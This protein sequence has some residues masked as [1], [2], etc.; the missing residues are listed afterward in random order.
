MSTARGISLSYSL[1]K[2]VGAPV[3]VLWTRDDDMHFE[4]YHPLSVTRVTARMDDIS[5]LRMSRSEARN[6]GIP[7]GAWRA[8]T[9]IPDAFARE[10]FIDEFAAATRQDTISLHHQLLNQ[11]ERNALDLVVDL[12]GWG[13]PL[14]LG[15]GRG[16]AVFST[17]GVSPCA[18]VAEVAVDENGQIRI[19]KVYC[20]ID[21]GVV[22]NPDM[23]RAQ[24]EGGILFGLTSTL[25]AQI[26][27][28][29]GRVE[30]S[31]FHDYPL[32]RMDET[33]E[34]VVQIVKSSADPTGTGEMANPPIAP[35]VANAI[36]A[37]TGK[38]IRRVPISRNA[39]LGA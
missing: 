10:S 36:F 25:K 4:Y 23:V 11:R 26:T 35:A 13:S 37:A 20:V 21:C 8:V 34:I 14:P 29:Q 9:N 32:L 5:T 15:R 39:L 19:L 22:I 33:P 30:Q 6:Y 17:W 16:L 24:M 3:Q 7:T 12:A 28:S 38:R 31:N 18:Q 2:Q 27:I 1:S